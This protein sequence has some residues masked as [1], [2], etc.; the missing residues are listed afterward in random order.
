MFFKLLLFKNN[1]SSSVKLNCFIVF[2][3]FLL[4]IYKP[5]KCM[6]SGVCSA[7]ALLKLSGYCTK[8]AC[9]GEL[10]ILYAQETLPRAAEQEEVI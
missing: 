5:S 7:N 2:F 3:F 8:K 10:V 9:Y 1:F 4:A 6:Y